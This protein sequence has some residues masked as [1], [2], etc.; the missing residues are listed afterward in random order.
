M[1]QTTSILRTGRKFDQVLSGARKVFIADGFEGASVDDIARAAGVS[2]ATLYSY[3]PDKRL[4]FVEVARVECERMSE[5]IMA[6]IDETRPAREG[7]GIAARALTGFLVTGFAQELFRICVAESKRFPDLGRAFFE[8]GP[9]EGCNRLAAYFEKMTARGELTIDDIPLA[10]EQFSELCKVKLWQ[11]ALFGIQTE[12]TQA[13]VV[14]VADH[15]VDMFLAR[16]GT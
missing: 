14:Y 11:R 9:N 15:A 7:L 3:F 10:A 1:T 13:E 5:E 8:N 2:K 16:Y 6:Q 12:F 4:L